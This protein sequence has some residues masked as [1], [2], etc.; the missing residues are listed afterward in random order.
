M[1]EREA[2]HMEDSP[3]C[4][5]SGMVVAD[6]MSRV[7]ITGLKPFYVTDN[8]KLTVIC[9][10]KYRRY[11]TRVEDNIPIFTETLKITNMGG[12]RIVLAPGRPAG[13]SDDI[14]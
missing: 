8:S 4:V 11:A 2:Y 9:P 10:E 5:P 7:W 3:F 12:Q 14:E 6:R 1:G 13:S